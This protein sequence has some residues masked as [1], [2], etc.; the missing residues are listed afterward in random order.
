MAADAIF[1]VP[2]DSALVNP[3]DR[4]GRAI[5]QNACFGTMR[6]LLGFRKINVSVFT[7]KIAKNPNFGTLSMHFL[8]KTKMII[9]FE[10]EVR[11]LWNLACRVYG[12]PHKVQYAQKSKKMKIQ[13]GRRRH[14]FLSTSE[15]RPDQTRGPI[16]ASDTSKRVFCPKEVPFGV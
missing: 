10:P 6:C 15:S 5:C 4:F 7:H 8:W 2:R 3:V 9:T 12:R 13:D 14:Y 1:C 11:S 16:L